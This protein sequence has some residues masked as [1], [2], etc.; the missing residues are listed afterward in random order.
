VHS[1]QAAEGAWRRRSE[2]TAT[3]EVVDHPWSQEVQKPH[4]ARQVSM[5]L[6]LEQRG[7]TGPREAQQ[8]SSRPHEAEIPEGLPVRAEDPLREHRDTLALQLLL[9]MVCIAVW[10]D[11]D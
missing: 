9:L 5:W 6:C 7:M 1:R 8:A 10:P 4:V 3:H 11:G 2:R